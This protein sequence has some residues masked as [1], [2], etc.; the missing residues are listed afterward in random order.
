MRT[1]IHAAKTNLSKLISQLEEEGGEV[2]LCRAGK[3]V[4][5]MTH[6]PAKALK[7]KGGLLAGQISMA[8]DFD[9]PD[10]SLFGI[11]K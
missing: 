4:A 8:D 9:M 2:L 3:P 7:R 5:R 11:K 1:N 6:V 10:G